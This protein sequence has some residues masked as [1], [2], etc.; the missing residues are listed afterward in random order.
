ML[1]D[2]LNVHNYRCLADTSLLLGTVS[3]FFGPNGAGKSTLLDSVW[4]LRDIAIRGLQQAARFRS[5]GSE[6]SPASEDNGPFQFLGVDLSSGCAK[7]GVIISWDKEGMAPYPAE[8]FDISNGESYTV[9]DRSG[10]LRNNPVV[11]FFDDDGNV[12]I[13]KE[14]FLKLPEPDQLALPLVAAQAGASPHLVRMN[15]LLR[16][17][18]FF[19][20]RDISLK[21]LQRFGSA[22]DGPIQSLSEDCSNIWAV[23][24]QLHDKQ[25]IDKRYK[26]IESYLQRAFPRF[27]GMIFEQS[28]P[29]EVIGFFL[30]KNRRE[31]LRASATP[32]GY[33]QMLILM[34]LLFS[35]PSGQ[36]T[37]LLL[38][39]PDLS[40][41]P[42][43]LFVLAEAI[44]DATKN[45]G[46]QVMM[47][48]HSPTLLN[49]FPEDSLYLMT[50]QEGRTTI[51]RVSEMVEPKELLRQYGAGYLYMSQLIGEQSPEQ[52]AEVVDADR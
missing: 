52:M 2:R 23:L 29:N 49:A 8:R 24:R 38:D 32:D 50:P 14:R 27:D 17:V 4:F 43:A 36:E 35:A 41:H 33:L 48:T 22:T 3:V 39:E 11:Y 9:Y 19:A 46:R 7:L 20:S 15:N 45:W 1:I 5:L 42:W 6:L 30:E 26:V 21:K 34:T 31:P 16:S 28:G 47:A 18:R 40:L 10:H 37:L 12:N 44:E 13:D 51:Q 25:R